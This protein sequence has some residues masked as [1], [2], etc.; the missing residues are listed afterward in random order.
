MAEDQIEARRA[1]RDLLRA[2][3]V[4]PY[5][6]RWHRTHTS[7]EARALPDETREV[8]L[9]GR[10][11]ARREISRKLTFL[12]LQDR[13]GRIQVSFRAGSLPDADLDLMRKALDTGDFLGVRGAMWTTRTGERTL[14]A[15]EVRILSKG[16]RPLPEKWSGVTD[17]ETCW[18]QRYLDLLTNDETRARFRMRTAL[19]R[20]IREHLD[21]HGFEEVDTPVLQTKASGALA[22]PFLSHHNALDMPVTLRIAPE[23]WLKRL[24]VG[25]Y[26]RVYEFARCFRNEGM[27]PSHL[28]DFTMLEYYAAWWSYEENMDFTEALV[29]RAVEKVTGGL[30][31][32]RRDAAGNEVVLDFSGA[33]PRRRITDLIRERTG[34][35]VLR[36]RDPESLRAWVRANGLWED[37]LAKV[38]WGSLVDHVYKKTVRPHLVQPVFIVGHPIELSPLAR[39]NDADPTITDRFQLVV[40][41][42]EVVNAYSELV[43]PEDQRRR[44]EE[45]AAARAGGDDEAMPTEE[46]YLLCME[47]GMP[48]T[49]G[50]GMGIDRMVTL[51]SGQDN[52]RDSVLFPLMRPE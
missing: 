52:L 31:V 28:Q 6:D 9:C 4:N 27:D 13:A 39:R 17:R 20:A 48:P 14:D 46:D 42:W 40:N 43:D 30:A 21:A 3:G 2:S 19:I 47:Y 7:E 26:E 45:Q 44:F 36:D 51:L 22:R 10:V 1:K 33:W 5:P 8:S 35:D 37:D 34:L 12:T 41:T 11:M 49:S 15:L 16:L 50:W 32:T 18:R 24:L 38:S 23:T 25:G 29:K